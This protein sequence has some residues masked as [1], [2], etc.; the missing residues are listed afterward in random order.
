MVIEGLS[1]TPITLTGLRAGDIVVVDGEQGEFKINGEL[2][3]DHF[4]GWEL[5]RLQPDAN[6]ITITNATLANIEIAYDLRY[7]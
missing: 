7:V 4:D 6:E 1:Q 3:W 2:A 5:P